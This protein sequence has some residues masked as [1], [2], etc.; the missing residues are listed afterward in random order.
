MGPD[1]NLWF[2]EAQG[3]K[4]GELFPENGKITEYTISTDSSSPDSIAIGPDG[5]L[6]FTENQRE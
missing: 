6:W 4:I 1:G 5:N 3:N 2:T